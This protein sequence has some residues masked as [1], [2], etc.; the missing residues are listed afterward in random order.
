MG[1][2]GQSGDCII[3]G[4]APIPGPTQLISQDSTE[5]ATIPVRVD[6]HSDTKETVP[7]TAAFMAVV[8]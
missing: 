2:C 6:G 8:L 4:S 1:S 5:L 3:S 7:G